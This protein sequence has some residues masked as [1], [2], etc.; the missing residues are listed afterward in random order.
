MIKKNT[1]KFS[2]AIGDS[3][4]EKS[5]KY[6]ESKGLKYNSSGAITADLILELNTG[7]TTNLGEISYDAYK[8][9]KG[10]T[11]DSYKPKN[12][13][14]KKILDKYKQYTGMF[15][16]NSTTTK[17]PDNK[18]NDIYVDTDKLSPNENKKTTEE[19]KQSKGQ[20]VVEKLEEKYGIDANKFSYSDLPK[21]QSKL[22]NVNIN[23]GDMDSQPT[24]TSKRDG[25][26][27]VFGKKLAYLYPRL[28][29][30]LWA[31]RARR[32]K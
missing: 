10:N 15:T 11:L 12:D 29:N 21:L 9:V 7:K 17:T 28:R 23:M 1:N 24:V 22:P 13:E 25:L 32:R 6:F 19:Q 5:K 16:P 3:K 31:R 27:G 2:K 4:S 8:A 14:E 30:R 20:T 18:T 26:F